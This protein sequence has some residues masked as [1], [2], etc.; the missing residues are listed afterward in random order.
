[1]SL[2]SLGRAGNQ[3]SPVS[4]RRVAQSCPALYLSSKTDQY[5]KSAFEG[6]LQSLVLDAL[7]IIPTASTSKYIMHMNEADG[8]ACAAH[9]CCEEQIGEVHME[10]VEQPEPSVLD[11]VG[12][13]SS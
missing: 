5:T 2:Q 3:S 7:I 4:I 11:E 6:L 9:A 10:E 13:L 1:M 8:E 12:L